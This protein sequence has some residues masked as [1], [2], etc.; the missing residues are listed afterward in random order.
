VLHLLLAAMPLLLLRLP[1]PLLDVGLLVLLAVAKA[2]PLGL[3]LL[4]FGVL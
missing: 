2:R 1:L 4:L 3:Q